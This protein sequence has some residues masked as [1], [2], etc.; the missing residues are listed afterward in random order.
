[1]LKEN[2]Y[3]IEDSTTNIEDEKFR[4]G[5]TDTTHFIISPAGQISMSGY[6]PSNN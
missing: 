6:I 4:I 1:V 2:Y 3:K 5:G